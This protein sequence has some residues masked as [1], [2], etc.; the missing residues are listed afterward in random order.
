MALSGLNGYSRD[1]ETDRQTDRL[2]ER[3]RQ[4]KKIVCGCVFVIVC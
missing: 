3:E 4:K 2:T 1:R